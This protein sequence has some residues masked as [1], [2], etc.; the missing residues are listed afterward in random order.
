MKDFGKK[1]QTK[2]YVSDEFRNIVNVMMTQIAKDDRYAQMLY[3]TGKRKYGSPAVNAM[4]QEWAQWR[5]G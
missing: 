4:L 5:R 3:K 2:L 1:E